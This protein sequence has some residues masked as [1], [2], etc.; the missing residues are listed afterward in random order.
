MKIINSRRV[1]VAFGGILAATLATGCFAGGPGYSQGPY[2]YNSNYSSYGSSYPD[3]GYSY[4]QSSGNSYNLGYQNGVRADGNRDNSRHVVVARNRVEAP[5]PAQNSP[6]ITRSIPATILSRRN[7]L[8]PARQRRPNPSDDPLTEISRSRTSHLRL[9]LESVAR[10]RGA[11]IADA[12]KVRYE[13]AAG[14][15]CVPSINLKV[16][17]ICGSTLL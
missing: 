7:G 17:S 2:G 11:E 16:G 8:N 5:A 13:L 14:Y 12:Q 6:S 10:F 1:V 4:P 9:R 3:S 15:I